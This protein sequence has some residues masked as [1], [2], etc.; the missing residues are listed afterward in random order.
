MEGYQ[1]YEYS[2][3]IRLIHKQVFNTRVAHC[4]FILDIGSRD[5]ESNQLGITHFWE[6]MAF[7]GTHKR[8]AFHIINRLDSVGGELNA[9][10][11]KEKTCFYASVLSIYFTKAVE[12]LCDITFDSIFPVKEIEKERSV[13]LEE[14]LMHEDDPVEM[15]EDD[16][17]ALLFA[18][19][20]LGNKII[21]TPEHI[22][23]INKT[24]FED[25]IRK[26][27]CAS[28]II[29]SSV[30]TLPFTKVVNTVRRYIETFSQF[31]KR[32][33]RSA[34]A[35]FKVEKIEKKQKFQQAHCMLGTH[36]F[37]LKDHRRILFVLLSNLLGG[38]AMNSRLNLAI[39]E[40]YGFVYHIDSNYT[41]FTDTGLFAIYFATEKKTLCRCIDLVLK[42]LKKLREKP[43][44]VLQLRAAKQQLIGQL[45]MAEEHNLNL[46]LA[47]GKSM[48]DL[49]RVDSL[50]DIFKSIE[51]ITALQLQDLANEMMAEKRFSL[52][53]FMPN[54]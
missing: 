50:T 31:E 2:N 10:T 48:L 28:N 24:N 49:G 4:G 6:H 25:F 18:N 39:R 29:F 41:A 22:K 47:I 40:K 38:E 54:E 45:A 8:K 7:K 11:T 9:Y 21:G 44:G 42:E 15:I 53:T 30:S 35:F 16:F 12:L 43:L 52:L 13:I 33:R 36:A 34:P 23:N 51:L 26:N 32:R 46:M 27:L 20:P 5:E 14:M 1:V 17:N 3:G 19:H 37:S